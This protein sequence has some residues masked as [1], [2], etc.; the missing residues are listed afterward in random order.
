MNPLGR[1][2]EDLV[3]SSRSLKDCLNKFGKDSSAGDGMLTFIV[4]QIPL[5]GGTFFTAMEFYGL[6]QMLKSEYVSRNDKVDEAFKKVFKVGFTF[7]TVLSTTMIGQLVIPIPI[8]GAL[9][10]GAVGGVFSSIVGKSIDRSNSNPT[11]AY[12]VFIRI[13]LKCMLPDGSWSFDNLPGVKHILARYFILTKSNKFADNLWL[14]IICFVNVSVYHTLLSNADG[15]LAT[16]EQQL[17]SINHQLEPTIVY[18]SE[19]ID[20]LSADC[21]LGK[22]SAKLSQLCSEGYIGL[23]VAARQARK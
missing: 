15:K 22:I 12:S 13:V 7:G 5:V 23:D 14:T 20:L 17:E 10:G 8:V 3:F 11:M 1:L 2:L 16:D 18:L 21:N 6:R 9:I 4:M 19:R